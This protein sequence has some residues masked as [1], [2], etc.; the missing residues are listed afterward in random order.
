MLTTLP[1]DDL[2]E[3]RRRTLAWAFEHGATYADVARRTGLSESQVKKFLAGIS[4]PD[5]VAA[6]LAINL[7]LGLVYLRPR[8]LPH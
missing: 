4:E 3:V 7:P 6:R 1:H 2:E 8:I 5:A